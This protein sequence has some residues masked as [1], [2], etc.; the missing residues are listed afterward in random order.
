MAFDAGFLAAV[1]AEIN[2]TATG[3]RVEKVYLPERDTVVLQMRTF[4]GGKRL[5]INVGGNNPRIGFTDSPRENPQ[6]PPMFCML[7]R[8]Y[9]NGAKLLGVRQAGFERVA[10]LDFETRDEMGFSCRRTLIAETMGKYSNLIF[11]DE[12]G[13]ILSAIRTVDFTT[14]S[15]RQVLPG[16][17]YE[18]PPKQDKQNPLE[19]TEAS[20]L[21][22]LAEAPV[23]KP[24]DKFITSEY[25]G[26]SAAVAR[27]IAFRAG[28]SVDCT[29]GM[30][31]PLALWRE[32]ATIIDAIRTGA[33]SPCVV[34][35][36]GGGA[37]VE[38]SF[39]QLTQYQSAGFEVR[40]MES[41]GKVLDYFYDNRD[42]QTRVHQYASDLLKILNN[43][44]ARILK[45]LE[46]QRAELAE[47]EKGISFKK[48]G[49]LITANLYLL[50]RGMESAE[51]TDYETLLPDGSFA[52]RTVPLDARLTPAANAQRLYKKYNKSKSA[53][54]ALTKQIALGEE[55]ERYV[56]TVL[57]SLSR[58]ET[59][60][61]LSEI[62]EELYR[63]GYASRMKTYVKAKLPKSAF[64]E[65]RT[66]SGY[67][68]LCGKNNLQNEQITFHV[69]EKS[70][71]WFH[72]KNRPGAHVLMQ[73][74]GE[75]PDAV[76]FTEA[77]EIAAYNSKAVSD[78]SVGEN[79]AVDY[80]YAKN[81]KK[82][83]AARPGFV[84]YHTNWTAYVTP[85]KDKVDALRIK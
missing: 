25:L 67:R 64:M 21:R 47:C 57:D 3:A 54:V 33:F 26:I 53:K 46:L 45:K 14:S 40:A 56:Q 84:I 15:L 17:T 39:C 38:Y 27:E 43:A 18:L 48:D 55:E 72:V 65:Y 66:T 30:C 9:L 69:A 11:T 78:G 41:P 20:F 44:H 24:V 37:P 51:L 8:K 49:D 63:S 22:L 79:V 10:F 2:Q 29:I 6:N 74:A 71:I 28:H 68:V 16:M 19:A 35:H 34:C 13:K 61:D 81:V 70:D 7:M 4:A 75:E 58:A 52:V 59:P 62:R 80:T 77:A 82:P 31:A 12:N 73:C 32:F 42:R 36:V 50:K 85:S 83:P 5:L 76:D 1:T 23:E 60:T